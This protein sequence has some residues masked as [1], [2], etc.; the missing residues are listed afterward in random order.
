MDFASDRHFRRS[1]QR[2]GITHVYGVNKSLYLLSRGLSCFFFVNSSSPCLYSL[3]DGQK[4][5][6]KI[7][8]AFKSMLIRYI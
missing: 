7:D 2:N 8:K 4:G 3:Q 5:F 6:E 1:Y